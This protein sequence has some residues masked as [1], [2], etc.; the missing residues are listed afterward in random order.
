MPISALEWNM[1]GL[2][3]LQVSNHHSYLPYANYHNSVNKGWVI[4]F[5]LRNWD[6]KPIRLNLHRERDL[7]ILFAFALVRS[8]RGSWENA[9]Y[10]ATYLKIAEKHDPEFWISVDNVFEE[11][12]SRDWHADLTT[13]A[14]APKTLPHHTIH[15]DEEIFHQ[16]HTLAKK[17]PAIMDVLNTSKQTKNYRPFLFFMS[18]IPGLDINPATVSVMVPQILKELK[19]QE[20]H[21]DVPGPMCCVLDRRVLKAAKTV[22][23]RLPQ[24]TGPKAYFEA[25]EKVYSLFPRDFELPL[26]AYKDLKVFCRIMS[27]NTQ[28]PEESE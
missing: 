8:H 19:C 9:V 15:F 5:H 24:I 7:F 6:G 18:L 10:F 14:V 23:I 11:I 27:N 4:D 17:W 25:A 21:P 1:A 3:T 16:L 22:G 26:F 13:M 2:L 28:M 12:L 20:L